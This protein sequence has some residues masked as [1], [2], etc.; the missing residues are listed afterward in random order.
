M[1][2]E[3]IGEAFSLGWRRGAVRLSSRRI[4]VMTA[5]D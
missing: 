1:G 3:T 2:V 4:G 5:N